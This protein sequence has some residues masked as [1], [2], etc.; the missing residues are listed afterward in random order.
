MQ[1]FVLGK[2]SYMCKPS[3]HKM[4]LWL[5]ANLLCRFG[6][7][8]RGRCCSSTT[9][10]A[11]AVPWIGI[12]QALQ[13]LLAPFWFTSTMRR[14]AEF[15]NDLCA[16]PSRPV[17]GGLRAFDYC[18]LSLETL[19]ASQLTLVFQLS[20]R[21]SLNLSWKCF[22]ASSSVF[23]KARESWRGNERRGGTYTMY[24]LIAKIK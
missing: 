11:P 22:L 10:E 20:R 13:H 12:V 3:K 2:V 23:P 7:P 19:C 21:A 17:L 9:A 5:N 1:T 16:S 24:E 14:G 4:M 8:R 6:A 18:R 15:C